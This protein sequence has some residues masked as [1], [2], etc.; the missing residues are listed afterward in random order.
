MPTFNAF[1]P[2]LEEQRGEI[3]A[4]RKETVQ[5]GEKSRQNLDLYFPPDSKPA[6]KHKVL[7]FAY[8]GGFKNGSKTLPLQPLAYGNL[9][10][11]FAKRGLLVAVTDYRL[12]PEA[13]YPSGGE[14][15][16]QAVKWAIE[17]IGKYGGDS[18]HISLLGNSAGGLW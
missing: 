7:M 18:N 14:D 12:I 8:G 2:L 3:E 17:N 9:G 11:F 4:I 10:A 15:I 5:Y 6:D 13:R 1:A 16:T